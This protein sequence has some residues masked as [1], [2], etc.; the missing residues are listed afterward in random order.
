MMI[1]TTIYKVHKTWYETFIHF[2]HDYFI[3]L[4]TLIM[5]H[6]TLYALYIK[7]TKAVVSSN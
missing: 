6:L 4:L 3:R 2:W 7:I 5:Q 1:T